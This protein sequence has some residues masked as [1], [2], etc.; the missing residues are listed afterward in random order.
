MCA[1]FVSIAVPT[2]N[3]AFLLGDCIRCALDQSYSNFELVIADNDDS[4][5]TQQVVAGFNDP[6]IKYFKTGGLSM[7]DNW[8]FAFQ[9]T[10]GEV[11][12]MLEDKQFLKYHALETIAKR[13]ADSSVDVVTW[14]SDSFDDVGLF[15]RVWSPPASRQTA[16]FNSDEVLD[17]FLKGRS[18]EWSHFLP[19]AHLSAVRRA[20]AKKVE[21]SITGRQFLPVSPDYTSAFQWLAHG[22]KIVCL[23]EALVVYGTKQH[24]N[25]RAAL[26]KQGLYEDFLREL[27][28]SDS[29]RYDRIPVKAMTVPGA[30]YN[31]YLHIRER[32]GGR[33]A[34][35]ELDMPRFYQSVHAYISNAF[36]EGV[37]MNRE[38]EAWQ[39]ALNAESPSTRSEVMSQIKLAHLKGRMS[40]AIKKTECFIKGVWKKWVLRRPEWRYASA[41][42]YIQAQKKEYQMS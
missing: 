13:F 5:A 14:S 19:I 40:Q 10:S 1:P 31:D 20:L 37:A 34:P 39:T 29:D 28:I 17:K 15:K 11:F 26:L 9:Q 36:K 8:E 4:A 42:D 12:T 41:I 25:G 32:L 22:E 6:R 24:S 16:V 23:A 30:I 18:S 33:L 38:L 7:P 2:K 27:K 21:L 3:R 35:H